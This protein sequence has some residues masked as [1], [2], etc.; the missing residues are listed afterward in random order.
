LYKKTEFVISK[1]FQAPG[2]QILIPSISSALNVKKISASLAIPQL[3]L[4][5]VV[6]PNRN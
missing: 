4:A 3:M 5:K 2:Y 1:L 6:K